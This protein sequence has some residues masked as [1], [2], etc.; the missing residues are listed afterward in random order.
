MV[1]E[2]GYSF[3]AQPDR[4]VFLDNFWLTGRSKYRPVVL[5][6]KNAQAALSARRWREVAATIN[7]RR[8]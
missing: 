4:P 3:I 1:G 7:D 6:A 8:G 5:C 2:P